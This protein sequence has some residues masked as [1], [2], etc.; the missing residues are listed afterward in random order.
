MRWLGDDKTVFVGQELL[1]DK[2]CVARCD[3]VGCP[4]HFSRRC[5][6][7]ASRDALQALAT[8]SHY[9]ERLADSEVIGSSE[10]SVLTRTAHCVTSQKTAFVI[11]TAVKSSNLT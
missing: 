7:T 9:E 5:L 6:R 10:T 3:M 2:R 1:H 4:C 8:E 11:V